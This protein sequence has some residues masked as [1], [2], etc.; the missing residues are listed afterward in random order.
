MIAGFDAF[1]ERIAENQVQRARHAPRGDLAGVFLE[2]G[3]LAGSLS[4]C[5]LLV[6]VACA[7][8]LFVRGGCIQGSFDKL[9]QEGD[10]TAEKKAAN[11]VLGVFQGAYWCVAT[12]IYLFISFTRNNWDSSWVIWPVAGV[13]FAAVFGILETVVK[14][15]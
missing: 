15:K 12:A 1:D 5:V 11:R 2:L 10:Y 3:A 8:W 7:V 6:V 13:L 9:L 4:V 14:K